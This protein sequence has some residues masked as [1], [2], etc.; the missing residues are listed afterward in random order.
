MSDVQLTEKFFQDIAGWEAVK[1]AR[2]YIAM[3]K[4]LS[5]NWSPPVLKGV[6]QAGGDVVPG[7]AGY[8]RFQ[9]HRKHLHLP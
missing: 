9:R 6:V 1:Q 3:G 7:R 8:Q 4:V 5:S 2:A